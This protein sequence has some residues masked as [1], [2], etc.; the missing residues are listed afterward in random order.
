MAVVEGVDLLVSTYQRM[1]PLIREQTLLLSQLQ[2]LV[3]DE[4]DTLFETGRLQPILE[5]FLGSRPVSQGRAQLILA[6]T[7]RPLP[8]RDYLKSTLKDYD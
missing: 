3:V 8:L 2:W 4:A 7:T 5:M 6:S 1:L